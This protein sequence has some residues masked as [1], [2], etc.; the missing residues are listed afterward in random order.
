MIYNSRPFDD[1]KE[2]VAEGLWVEL[3]EQK[4][5]PNWSDRHFIISN[6]GI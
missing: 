2:E 1:E 4:I 3:E 6:K 5:G